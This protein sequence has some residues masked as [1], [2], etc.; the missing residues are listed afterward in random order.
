MAISKPHNLSDPAFL[1]FGARPPHRWVV[2]LIKVIIKKEFGRAGF[3]AHSQQT[4]LG[5]GRGRLEL[6]WSREALTLKENN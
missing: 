3:V 2:V 1:V 6:A 5:C 4:R